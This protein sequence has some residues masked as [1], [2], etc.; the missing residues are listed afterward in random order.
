MHD[1]KEH[2]LSLPSQRRGVTRGQ[3]GKLQALF[4]TR[5]PPD[6]ISIEIV[7]RHPRVDHERLSGD[8]GRSWAEQ[9]RGDICRLLRLHGL[10]PGN[11]LFGK[12]IRVDVTRN[13]RRGRC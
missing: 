10:P 3:D 5:C 7:D 6:N 8:A 4:A 9:E 12:Q 13:T 1:E 2:L 11:D